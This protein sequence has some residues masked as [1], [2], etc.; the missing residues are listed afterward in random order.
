MGSSAGKIKNKTKNQKALKTKNTLTNWIP[1]HKVPEGISLT[2]I[3]VT[4]RHDIF[5]ISSSTR[6]IH[7]GISIYNESTKKWTFYEKLPQKLQHLEH[8]QPII[9]SIAFDNNKEDLYMINEMS[10]SRNIIQITNIM[11]LNDF[12]INF[13]ECDQLSNL[14]SGN[15]IRRLVHSIIIN[16]KYHIFIIDKGKPVHY[17]FNTETNTFDKIETWKYHAFDSEFG[18]IYVEKNKELFL[19]GGTY[20]CYQMSP[21]I[22][23]Y[24][25]PNNCWEKLNVSLPANQAY[26][27]YV[28]DNNQNNIIIFGGKTESDWQS[29]PIDNI[30]IFNIESMEL[31]ESHIKCPVKGICNAVVVGSALKD[32]LIVGAFVRMFYDKH[33]VIDILKTIKSFYGSQAE[34]HLFSVDYGWYSEKHYGKHWK[35]SLSVL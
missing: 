16:G 26:F 35:I 19:F 1:L 12:K 6:P 18:L 33:M 25:F 31:K 11:S 4:N 22:Y 28:L 32:D 21:D 10:T 24:S 34:I 23:K 15:S 20:N 14:L 29:T 7:F 3:F 5:S 8:F 30:Y 17:I 13:I 2:N 9:H 27:G